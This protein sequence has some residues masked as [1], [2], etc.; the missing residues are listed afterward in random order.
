MEMN[1]PDNMDKDNR[2]SDG[3]PS[4]I[5]LAALVFIVLFALGLF[6][7]VDV[8]R[9][10]STGLDALCGGL[11]DAATALLV[12]ATIALIFEV[13][14]QRRASKASESVVQKSLAPIRSFLSDLQVRLEDLHAKSRAT[15]EL[16]HVMTVAQHTGIT[17]IFENRKELFDREVR[18]RLEQP[19]VKRI[20]MVGVS[21]RDF[22]A[23]DA[24][25]YE[26][27]TA[28]NETIRRLRREKKPTPEVAA[29]IMKGDCADADLRI[30]IEEG[31]EFRDTE[32]QLHGESWREK[33]R[34]WSDWKRVT[35]SWELHFDQVALYEFEHLPTGWVLLLESSDPAKSAVYVE[36]YHYGRLNRGP[37]DNAIYSCLGGKCPVL[38]FAHGDAYEIFRNHLRAMCEAS[39]KREAQK[40]TRANNVPEDTSRKLADPQH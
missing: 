6:G 34:L 29:V 25:L 27:M 20:L 2:P 26:T 33:S 40:V 39:T 5:L 37:S 10:K 32:R 23:G 15:V 14:V 38:K 12:G 24:P 16:S 28:L 9:T 1:I 19:D 35:D 22:F 31:T 21:L 13:V 8:L 4:R 3:R 7:V 30:T 18:K 17:D 36:Q 11:R